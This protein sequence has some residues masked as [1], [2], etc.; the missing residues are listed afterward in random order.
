MTAPSDAPPIE[1]S[2]PVL[3]SLIPTKVNLH[4]TIRE[5]SFVFLTTTAQDDLSSQ[6]RPMGSF[7]LALPDVC[8]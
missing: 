5:T 6:L 1:I 4:L 2:F 7:V 8:L 3:K